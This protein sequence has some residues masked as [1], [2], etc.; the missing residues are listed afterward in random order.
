MKYSGSSAIDLSET[1]RLSEK[2]GDK[3]RIYPGSMELRDDNIVHTLGSRTVCVVGID[4]SIQGAREISL[5]GIRSIDGPLRNREDIASEDHI[6]KSI[7]KIKQIRG[8]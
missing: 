8:N 3:M 7:A 5:N 4:E 2:Y 6:S 1:Y